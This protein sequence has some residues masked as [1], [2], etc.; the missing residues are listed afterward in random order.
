MRALSLALALTLLAGAT[1]AGAQS[2]TPVRPVNP[3]VYTQG[4]GDSTWTPSAFGLQ[5]APDVGVTGPAGLN[6]QS[7]TTN[8]TVTRPPTEPPRPPEPT[9]VWRWAQQV[10]ITTRGNGGLRDGN[11][12]QTCEGSAC[13]YPGRGCY[14]AFNPYSG[15][16]TSQPVGSIADTNNCFAMI[17]TPNP[18]L[19]YR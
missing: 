14:A 15:M 11:Q 17:L 19:C 7:T 2:P 9:Q 6:R 3:H 18:A 10:C 13:P 12:W 8:T 5:S 4:A 1:G 16:A